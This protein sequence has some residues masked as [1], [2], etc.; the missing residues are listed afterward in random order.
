MANLIELLN[1]VSKKYSE[2]QKE[3][4]NE[5]DE[6]RKTYEKQFIEFE[7]IYEKIKELNTACMDCGGNGYIGQHK[8]VCPVCNGTGKKENNG[9]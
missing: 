4:S 1:T 2:L 6:L 3:F 8:Y 7:A 5:R 9:G